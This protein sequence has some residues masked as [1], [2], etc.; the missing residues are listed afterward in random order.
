MLTTC[1]SN[2]CDGFCA[3]FSE[4]VAQ[5]AMTCCDHCKLYAQFLEAI[6]DRCGDFLLLAV[7]C[8]PIRELEMVTAIC[9]IASENRALIGSEVTTC[10]S[11][12]QHPSETA[13]K[14][15]ALKTGHCAQFLEAVGNFLVM[16]VR[17]PPPFQKVTLLL[18]FFFNIPIL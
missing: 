10:H 3:W 18:N 16:P 5:V 14:N 13:S 15:Q 6:S 8:G 12:S 17:T 7:T 9:V 11:K 1:H 4:A 2:L